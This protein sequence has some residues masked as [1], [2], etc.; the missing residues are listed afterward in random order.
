MT[1]P[2][3]L[4]SILMLNSL[5]QKLSAWIFVFDLRL[6]HDGRL[7]V[8]GAFAVGAGASHRL[9]LAAS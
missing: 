6:V 4:I 1:S 2:L 5:E 3:I 7:C 9:L 8:D